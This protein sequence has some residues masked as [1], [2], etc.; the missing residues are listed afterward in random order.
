MNRLIIGVGFQKHASPDSIADAI[1]TVLQA[2]PDHDVTAIAVPTDKARSPAL[3]AAA[4]ERGWPVMTISAASLRAV[5][6][7]V[8]TR[9]TVSIAHRG[10]G[11]VCEA[12]ALAGA[13][14]GAQLVVPRVFSADRRATAAA[15]RC[16]EFLP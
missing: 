15:A 8:V 2:L 13:G 6:A 3:L 14:S 10:V 1:D 4:G 12:A 9:S 11:S 5:D 7:Q 16:Q